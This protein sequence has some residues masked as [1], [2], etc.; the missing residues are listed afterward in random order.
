M[1]EALPRQKAL[2]GGWG[3]KTVLSRRVADSDPI[4]ESQKL[5]DSDPISESQK[6]MLVPFSSWAGE[7]RGLLPGPP[8]AGPTPR[9]GSEKPAER[10]H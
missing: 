9:E 4:S 3:S 6:W 2:R 8:G 1:V 7:W 10:S 5:A